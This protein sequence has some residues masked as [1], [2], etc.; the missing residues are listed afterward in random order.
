M[1]EK[2]LQALKDEQTPFL[3]GQF[4]GCFL[5]DSLTESF[6]VNAVWN[7]EPWWKVSVFD[8]P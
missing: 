2:H 8:L 6:N 5:P 3:L 1:L 7:R 4:I